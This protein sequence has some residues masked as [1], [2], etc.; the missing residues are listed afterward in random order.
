MAMTTPET[1]HQ[2]LLALGERIP[3]SANFRPVIKRYGSVESGLLSEVAYFLMYLASSDEAL[4]PEEGQFIRETTGLN[5]SMEEIR[6]FILG[7]GILKPSFSSSIP[8]IVSCAAKSPICQ[9]ICELFQRA[10]TAFLACDGRIVPDELKAL[11]AY[12]TMLWDFC[13]ISEREL[14]SDRAIADVL[15]EQECLENEGIHIAGNGV[16]KGLYYYLLYCATL[17]APCDTP[18]RNWVTALVRKHLSFPGQPLSAQGIDFTL[19]DDGSARILLETL[20]NEPDTTLFGFASMVS[21]K[22]LT[23]TSHGR[24]PIA[25]KFLLAACCMARDIL[26]ATPSL[27]LPAR[28]IPKCLSRAANVLL[29]ADGISFAD[30]PPALLARLDNM[31]ADPLGVLTDKSFLATGL[32]AAAWREVK[33]IRNNS[34]STEDPESTDGILAQLDNLIG[35]ATVKGEV[36]SLAN[37]AMISA[38]RRS[39]GLP[40]VNVALHLA[41][42]GNPGTGKTTVARLLA[43]IYHSLGILSKGHLVE[44]SRADLVA[45]FVGQT[46][47]K[48]AKV[49]EKAYGGVLFIDEAYSLVPSG[50]EN[51]FGAEAID[52]LL[53]GMEDRREDFAVVVAGYPAPMERFLDSNPGLR[54][55]FTTIVEFADYTPEEATL[56]FSSLAKDGGFVP[57]QECLDATTRHFRQRIESGTPPFAN[58]REARTLFEHAAMNQANRLAEKADPTD[59][60]LCELL[61]EDIT[62]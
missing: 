55:R 51:D 29:D 45:G 54:S 24:P 19:Q 38:K 32:E 31:L 59:A 42:T 36:R 44:V 12:A 1:L 9:P 18:V 47:M 50:V 6:G 60:E 22:E 62:N 41:F 15:Q 27:P 10:G 16:V 7:S 13:L 23:E 5:M 56:I 61:A 4:S 39:R 14:S 30:A 34:A 8:L 53:K 46:A 58:G 21:A 2:A 43:K 11:S 20:A 49:L 25:F 52:T 48:T 33:S 40:P 28:H 3:P 57:T 35:L 17:A 26:R 37:L